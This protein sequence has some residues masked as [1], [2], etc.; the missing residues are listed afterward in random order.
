MYKGCCNK[1]FSKFQSRSLTQIGIHYVQ[2]ELIWDQIASFFLLRIIKIVHAESLLE[3][4]GICHKRSDSY[5][6]QHLNYWLDNDHAERTQGER[7]YPIKSYLC[8]QGEL[9]CLIFSTTLQARKASLQSFVRTRCNRDRFFPR[10][11]PYSVA[12][13]K[14]KEVAERV[15]RLTLINHRSSGSRLIARGL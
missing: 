10:F 1:W 4:S 15:D 12:E 2:Y 11:I 6:C 8:Q 7:Y 9:A 13:W 3:C 14:E 5:L